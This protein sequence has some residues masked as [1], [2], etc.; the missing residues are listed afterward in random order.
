[1]PNACL[2]N[3]TITGCSTGVGFDSGF[4]GLSITNDGGTVY[5]GFSGSADVVELRRDSSTGVLTQLDAPD[6]C[7]SNASTA[8]CTTGVALDGA[9][10]TAVSPDD[11]SLY[12]ASYGSGAVAVFSRTAGGSFGH[13]SVGV[14]APGSG[15]AG[16]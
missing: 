16:R 9:R 13:A 7:V 15:T 2:S 11:S 1:S 14:S 3:D 4:Q 5:A 8:G 10:G 6:A 12:V